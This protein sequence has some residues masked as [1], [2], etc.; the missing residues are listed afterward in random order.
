[1]SLGLSLA[2]F[3]SLLR[4]AAAPSQAAQNQQ[5]TQGGGSELARDRLVR[6]ESRSRALSLT[7]ARL[8]SQKVLAR[9]AMP[10]AK[11]A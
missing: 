9:A 2:S 6:A 5:I 4:P 7:G 1:M 10:P 3:Q 11:R 8:S